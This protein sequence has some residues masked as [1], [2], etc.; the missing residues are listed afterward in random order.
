MSGGTMAAAV[1]AARRGWAVFPCRFRSKRPLVPDHAEADCRRAGYCSGRH[2]GWEQL[3]CADPERIAAGVGVAWGHWPEG[4]N[5]GIACGPSGLVPI[6]LDTLKAGRVLAAEWQDAGVTDGLD[7]LGVLASRAAQPISQTYTVGT[8]RG[9]FQ[10]YYR[11]IEGRQIRNS[12]EKIGPMIDHRGAGGYVVGAGSVLD[13]RAYDYEVSLVRGGRYVLLDGREPVPL[14]GW[15]ADLADPLQPVPEPAGERPA[16]RPGDIAGPRVTVTHGSAYARLRGIVA[17]TL[18]AADGQ[19][20]H[21]LHWAACRAGEM[22]RA[23]EVDADVATRALLK[24][25]RLVGLGADEARR[26]IRSG[27]R[28]GM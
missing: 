16:Q 15:L 27:L 1:E 24:A 19:R 20:N 23:G 5:V 13:Q 7:V 12:A 14:P 21:T 17:S 8:P 6:D 25:A 9:G 4:A 2:L 18:E 3:A 11:A 26:T 22:V 28:R 10:L